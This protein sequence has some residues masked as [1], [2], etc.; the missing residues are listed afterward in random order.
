[1]T[2]LEK[3]PKMWKEVYLEGRKLGTNRG[4][5]LGKEIADSLESN[6]ETGD[7][8]KDLVISGIPKFELMDQAIEMKLV[9]GKEEVP[10]L[11]KPDTCKAD[12]TAFKEYKTGLETD[13]WTQK[14]VDKNDQITFYSTGLYILTKKIPE[15]ELI[16]APT[17]KIDDMGRLELTGELLRFKTKRKYGEIINMMVRMRKAW[18]EM[19]RIA[20]EEL[21]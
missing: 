20:D 17:R 5:A 6:V 21:I 7:M 3:S 9:V 11:I 18:A 10:I 14:K 8:V 1:M 4:Q 2:M 15:A 19:G 12:Y 13:P 16:Y